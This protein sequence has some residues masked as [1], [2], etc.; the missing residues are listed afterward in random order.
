MKSKSNIFILTMLLLFGAMAFIISVDT[1]FRN[2]SGTKDLLRI[3]ETQ[4]LL[5]FVQTAL[6][7][8]DPDLIYESAYSLKAMA[9]LPLKGDVVESWALLNNSIQSLEILNT[10]H[11]E[12]VANFEKIVF[13]K[14]KITQLINEKQKETLSPSQQEDLNYL[15]V[16]LDSYYKSLL[17]IYR[18]DETISLS[19]EA[20]YI[21]AHQ[22]E[23]K[24]FVQ[25]IVTDGSGEFE[26]LEKMVDGFLSSEIDFQANLKKASQKINGLEVQVNELLQNKIESIEDLNKFAIIGLI[27]SLAMTSIGLFLLL[28]KLENATEN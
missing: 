6:N 1:F 22:K 15:E 20:V 17:F 21:S 3:K 16:L 12:R 25:K 8:G 13:S 2:Q 4:H 11:Q 19:E 26:N 23:A 27:L 7:V 14:N 5:T 18:P 24:E 9:D 10:N 28:K